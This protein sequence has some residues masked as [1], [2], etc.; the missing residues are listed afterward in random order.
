LVHKSHPIADQ[1]TANPL[2]SLDRQLFSGF[3]RNEMH[4]RMVNGLA[5]R[6]GVIPII[7][8]GPHISRDE[9]RAD[10]SNV[11][12]HTKV[13]AAKTGATILRE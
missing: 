3:D 6:L 1:P 12:P 9:L 13:R 10:Q 2:N 11:M 4:V 8:V 5:E 7:L